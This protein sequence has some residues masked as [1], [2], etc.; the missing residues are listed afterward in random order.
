[1]C[2][3]L[4]EEHVREDG[5]EVVRAG[6]G[7]ISRGAEARHERLAGFHGDEE[8]EHDEM[9]RQDAAD[10][11]HHEA[12]EIRAPRNPPG[13]GVGDDEAGENEEEIDEH[14]A[15]AHQCG[16]ADMARDLSVEEDDKDGGEPAPTVERFET[17][18]R[19]DPVCRNAACRNWALRHRVPRSLGS[20]CRK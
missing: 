5:A 4:Y 20:T 3:H 11:Q 17:S 2:S 1:M 13:I 8:R 16:V 9:K 19:A 18:L 6:E 10:A 7:S 15:R 14:L 12:P